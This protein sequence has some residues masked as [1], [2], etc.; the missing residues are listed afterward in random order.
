MLIPNQ[1][2]QTFESL[3]I[4]NLITFIHDLQSTHVVYV[5]NPTDQKR[6]EVIKILVDTYQLY[7]TTDISSSHQIV[8]ACQID[9]KWSNKRSN[10]IDKS[11]Y[12]V[13]LILFQ[14]I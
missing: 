14:I 7:V 13:R 10:I 4:Q 12:E 3:P 8:G 2:F 9:P 5:H 6:Y 11:Q 1:R